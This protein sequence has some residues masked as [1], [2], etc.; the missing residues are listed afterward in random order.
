[1]RVYVDDLLVTGTKSEA[2]DGFF[3]ELEDLALKNLGQ[4]HKFL[5]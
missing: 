1:M 2:V 4:A 3:D 5:E